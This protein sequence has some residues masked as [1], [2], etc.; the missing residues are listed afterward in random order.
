[1]KRGEKREGHL[2]LAGLATDAGDAGYCIN[3]KYDDDAEQKS[4]YLSDEENAKYDALDEDDRRD[5][6]QMIC[7]IAGRE[8]GVTID[9]EWEE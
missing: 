7:D 8:F 2:E 1:M 4:Y 5:S 9:A 6:T 3:F